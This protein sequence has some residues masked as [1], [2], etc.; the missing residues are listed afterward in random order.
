MGSKELVR[1]PRLV[2]GSRVGL[3]APAGPLLERDDLVRGQELCRALDWEPVLL[4]HA[5]GRHG[6]LAGSDAERLADL[7]AALRDPA[8]DAIWC[9]RG[10]YGVTRI[11][12]QVDFEAL[13]ARPRA[14]IGYSD[15]TA[16]LLAAHHHTGLVTFHGPMARAPLTRFSRD[17]QGRVLTVP[18]RAGRLGRL[19]APA[20]VLVPRTPRI[21]TIRGGTAEGP[22]LGG[23]LT[24]IQ[25]LLGTRHLPDFDGAILFF[26]DI[27]EELYR[28][29][30]M[31]AHL[32]M[33]GVLDRVAGV[34]VGQVT[35]LTRRGADGALGYDEVLATYLE[36]LGVPVAFGFPI[37][38]VED[39]WTVPI[40]IRA[41]LDATAGE[42]DLLETAVS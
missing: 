26:E 12:D 29:D 13:A 14:I 37:G 30:R 6:Y 9:L 17:H 19:P 28:I 10:G 18:Q 7:N 36:P 40:G 3:L 42:L 11:L 24:L 34:A 41:R 39:Q 8:L 2:P 31:L 22:L 27:G 16:L 4:P 5:S 35:E 33:A 15:V 38:H 21:V 25:C 32:R 23:N 1:P 20:E